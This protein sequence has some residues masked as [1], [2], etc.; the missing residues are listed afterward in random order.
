MGVLRGGKVASV[1]KKKVPSDE[2]GN[3]E[4]ERYLWLKL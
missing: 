4:V 2:R 1:D 3:T